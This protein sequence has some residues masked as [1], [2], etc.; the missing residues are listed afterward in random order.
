MT[1]KDKQKL[2]EI[3]GM[4]RNKRI[5]FASQDKIRELR[6]WVEQVLKA[7]GIPKPGSVTSLVSVTS[8][9][10]LRNWPRLAKRLI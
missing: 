9:V 3:Q 6:P 2:E 5:V 8:G 10:T 1:E 4:V 7:L